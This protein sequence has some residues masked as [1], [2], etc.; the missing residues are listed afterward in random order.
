MRRDTLTA[1]AAATLFLLGPGALAAP[2]APTTPPRSRRLQSAY[3]RSVP[4]GEDAA[5][6]RDLFPSVL[7]RVRRSSVVADIDLAALAAAAT[8]AI[9]TTPRGSGE[10]AAV[11]RKAVHAAL[12]PI[13]PYFRYFD[14]RSS[15]SCAGEATG[16][17]GGL[18][19]ELEAS[20]SALRV[21]APCPAVP[22][23]APAWSRAT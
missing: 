16:S 7:Q 3:E 23:S 8:K 22:P 1:W 20:G 12:Q 11:F 13:D 5:R 15:V 17:F 2:A 14:P 6:Y 21:V 9:E 18:G 10:P 4:P 19:I